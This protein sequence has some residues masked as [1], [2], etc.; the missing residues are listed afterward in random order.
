MQDLEATRE[1][2]GTVYQ[3]QE[4]QGGAALGLGHGA[5]HYPLLWQALWREDRVSVFR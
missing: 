5:Q 1:Y 3:P 2:G 4:W